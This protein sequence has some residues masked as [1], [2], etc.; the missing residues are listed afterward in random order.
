[1]NPCVPLEGGFIMSS[2]IQQAGML[3]G[4]SMTMMVVVGLHALAI[5][6]LIT[7]RM[8]P[9]W[10]DPGPKAMPWTVFE[11]PLPPKSV[12]PV[13]P[14]DRRAKVVVERM[15]LPIPGPIPEQLIVSEPIA[16]QA[17]DRDPGPDVG[18]APVETLRVETAL[19]YQIV[20]PTDDYYPN[21]SL[22]QQEHGVAVIR[23]CV[24]SAGRIAPLPTVET[25]S[26]HR[27]L[28]DA[29]IR[30]ARES[31]RFTPA[32]RD[33]VA[34]AACKGFRVNFSLR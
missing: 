18:G 21:A 23:V 3:S 13:A 11:D 16:E 30:W 6:A 20:R 28:D 26:G 32:T 25:S 14:I 27:R 33:G 2:Q 19:Q 22:V 31:L 24:D 5:T 7:W 34:I 15:S 12:E 17:P 10:I 1:M 8:A 9:D 29:A 4:R